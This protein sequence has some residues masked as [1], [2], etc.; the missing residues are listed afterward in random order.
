MQLKRIRGL[1]KELGHELEGVT[2]R[3][4]RQEGER[5]IYQLN[6]YC[7]YLDDGRRVLDI[8]A[9]NTLKG[10][11]KLILRDLQTFSD[12]LKGN[13]G[14][15]PLSEKI[16][17]KLEELK[18]L[19]E[20]HHLMLSEAYKRM[21]AKKGKVSVSIAKMAALF[22]GKLNGIREIPHRLVKDLTTYQIAQGGGY[23]INSSDLRSRFDQF[24]R[25]KKKQ[26]VHRI[27]TD[28]SFPLVV[29]AP[30]QNE[31][32]GRLLELIGKGTALDQALAGMDLSA[33][34]KFSTIMRRYSDSVEKAITSG[35][36]DKTKE[37]VDQ[38][39]AA[40]RETLRHTE[41]AVGK[42]IAEYQALG[43]KSKLTVEGSGDDD[44]HRALSLQT[45]YW[46]CSTSACVSLLDRMKDISRLTTEAFDILESSHPTKKTLELKLV[47]I[48]RKMNDFHDAQLGLSEEIG[49]WGYTPLFW[50]TQKITDF[51][52]TVR[53][54]LLSN[55]FSQKM[56]N[57]LWEQMNGI[58]KLYEDCVAFRDN[59]LKEQPNL[60]LSLPLAQ[61]VK[62]AKVLKSLVC[63]SARA[64]CDYQPA[65]TPVSYRKLSKTETGL[66]CVAFS[67]H[68]AG[69]QAK[70][71]K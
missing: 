43:E 5:L 66:G 1:V 49:P 54:M 21:E 32:P 50:L 61:V 34:P 23:K 52:D 12:L 28:T 30:I 9:S 59:A 24:N 35:L 7:H 25:L 64:M 46:D 71:Q 51:R 3:R 37:E 16:S 2:N 69:M 36:T 38:S 45:A 27:L 56:T 6:A 17:A 33:S 58:C 68:G 57:G 47:N 10:D 31:L 29:Y 4:L 62:T 11:L 65:A 14:S 53:Y 42:R 8:G 70:L 44:I 22:F 48:D 55:D 39:L 63:D 19:L 13:G 41:E 20:I 60:A 67:S 40:L 15:T 26:Q 18:Q